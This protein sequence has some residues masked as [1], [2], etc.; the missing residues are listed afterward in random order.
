MKILLVNDY[1]KH[2]GAEA[3][4]HTLIEGMQERGHQV[5]LATPDDSIP[6]LK[7]L[8][9]CPPE[10]VHFNNIC[11]VGLEPMR[12]CREHHVPFIW[13]VHDYYPVCKTRVRLKP[14]YTACDRY[15]WQ[16]CE[17]CPHQFVN[18]PDPKVI[19]KETRDTCM[20][21]TS[22]YMKHLFQRFGYSSDKIS[23]I[24]NGIKLSERQPYFGSKDYLLWSGRFHLEKGLPLYIKAA[25][26]LHEKAEFHVTGEGIHETIDDFGYAKNL[27]MLP[28]PQYLEEMAHCRAF[29]STSIWPEP[30]GYTQLEAQAAGRAVIG[31]MNGGLPE[32]LPDGKAGLLVNVDLIELVDA[33]NYLIDN[34]DVA[35]K[36]G[37]AAWENVQQYDIKKTV[38]A[39]ARLYEECLTA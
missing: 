30:V 28:R 33:I 6:I 38:D 37:Q 36:M 26:Y 9:D 31:F 16:D 35:C 7:R 24:K 39:Y 25:E 29:V 21:T 13:T 3:F 14:D 15:D 19:F 23:V 18:L 10:L 1:A 32:Y 34:P 2:A 20:V 27:G 12:Y 4:C 22:Q 8:E 17:G 5:G 11:R